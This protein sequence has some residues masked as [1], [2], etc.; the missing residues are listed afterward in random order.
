[1]NAALIRSATI[2]Q[3]SYVMLIS[4]IRK[5]SGRSPKPK[6][7]INKLPKL[8]KKNKSIFCDENK[9]RDSLI[10]RKAIS[11]ELDNHPLFRKR[12][13]RLKEKKLKKIIDSKKS[14]F[15]SNESSVSEFSSMKDIF[16]P[17]NA[18]LIDFNINKLLRKNSFD[19]SL[20]II[21]TQN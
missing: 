1:M 3:S 10:Q 9:L 11:V 15:F 2:A 8:S 7:I 4:R 18:S 16:D 19:I 17:K 13:V 21:K 5:I 20:Y 14:S 6:P 12:I